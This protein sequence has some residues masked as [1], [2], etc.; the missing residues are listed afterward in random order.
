MKLFQALPV[1][2]LLAGQALA[3][4]SCKKFK[5][6]V[7]VDSTNLV[8][9]APHFKTN[10][11]IADFIDTIGSRSAPDPS[12]AFSGTKN[13]TATYEIGATFCTPAK[14]H[15]DT[16][17]DTVLIATHGLNFDRE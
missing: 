13:V 16:H 15:K 1:I 8:Y 17:K 14:G 6:P 3:N 11:D 9:A 10:F 2:S 12:G 7:T 5:I 4:K